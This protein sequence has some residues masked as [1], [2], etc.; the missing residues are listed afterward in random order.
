MKPATTAEREKSLSSVFMKP[1]K[2]GLAIRDGIRIALVVGHAFETVER[3]VDGA[4]PI[5]RRTPQKPVDER[6]PS[7]LRP[8]WHRC[9]IDLQRKPAHPTAS[10]DASLRRWMA[11]HPFTAVL[12][13]SRW[14]KRAPSTL[15]PVWHRCRIHLQPGRRIQ[16][17]RPFRVMPPA[18]PA[19][20]CCVARIAERVLAATG[21]R[22]RPR[23]TALPHRGRVRLPDRR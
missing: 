22:T 18:A 11:L 2:S 7:T 12:R 13:K 20:G 23:R 8:V 4:S 5:H 16:G 17:Y 21:N 19:D 9:R 15:R 10:S 1:R 3:R 6:A 14:M